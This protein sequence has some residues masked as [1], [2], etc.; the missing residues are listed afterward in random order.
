MNGHR[1]ER[2]DQPGKGSGRIQPRR[3][4]R[5]GDRESPGEMEP[6]LRQKANVVGYKRTRRKVNR[7]EPA[8]LFFVTC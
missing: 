4:A 6:A 5:S 7:D 2:H 3:S 1:E 8:A